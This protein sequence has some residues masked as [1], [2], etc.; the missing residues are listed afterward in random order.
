MT[1]K[2][3][4]P[5]GMTREQLLAKWN[6]V[7]EWTDGLFTWTDP[8]EIS[9]LAEFASRSTSIL[10]IG[11]YHGKSALAMALANPHA[12]ITCIDICDEP[13]AEETFAKNLA[14]QIASGQLQFVKGTSD[15]LNHNTRLFDFAWI[16]GGHLAPDVRADIANIMPHMLPGSIICGHDYRIHDPEDG[17][18]IAVH[19]A[20][21]KEQ[22]RLYNSIWWVQL[23]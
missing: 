13:S 1:N 9:L 7:L 2:W 21:S 17:V 10:E 16:D 15:W 20:F 19:E 18:N 4:T 3:E 22:I 23:P 11:S 12:K 6:H 14:T 5:W 8:A